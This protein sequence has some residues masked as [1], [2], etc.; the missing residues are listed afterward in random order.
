MTHPQPEMSRPAEPSIIFENSHLAAVNKPAGLVVHSDGKTVEPTLCDWLLLRYPDMRGVGEPLILNKGQANELI[1][2]RPGIVHR[3]DRDTSGVI[4]VAKTNE[5]FQFLKKQ[6]QEREIRKTYRAIV[7]GTVK[8][9]TGV[10]DRPIGRSKTDFRRWSAERF[11]RGELRPAITEYAVL[12]RVSGISPA[13][14]ETK[15]QK[16]IPHDFTYVEAYPKTG[17][18]HQ[19]RVHFKAVSHPILCDSLY[20]PN[21]PAALGFARTALHAYKIQVTDLDGTEHEFEAGLPEDFRKFEESF[22]E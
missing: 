3:L 21:H 7:W 10:I 9:D 8:G 4:I 13:L 22:I 15:D 12:Q 14:S 5:S 2:D 1:I 6:F 17:R 20:A 16:K 18:T 11:A 19:I